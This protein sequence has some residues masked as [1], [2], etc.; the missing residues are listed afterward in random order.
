MS[1]LLFSQQNHV[2]QASHLSVCLDPW[3]RR[4]W[5][6]SGA[7]VLGERGELRVTSR[8][9][10]APAQSAPQHTS[11][12]GAPANQQQ[13]AARIRLGQPDVSPAAHGEPH[14]QRFIAHLRVL[15][16][17]MCVFNFLMSCRWKIALVKIVSRTQRMRT[18]GTR[19]FV[20]NLTDIFHLRHNLTTLT[21]HGVNLQTYPTS[22]ISKQTH[23]HTLCTPVERNP[24]PKDTARTEQASPERF[25]IKT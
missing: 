4:G 9:S 22:I 19:W 5:S 21:Q 6:E 15:T 11:P 16:Q 1:S 13:H 8:P 17:A 2:F 7:H 12:G 14:C 3:R 10:A 25:W 23:T 18:V 24:Q 20:S